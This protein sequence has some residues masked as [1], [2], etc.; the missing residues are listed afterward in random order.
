[1][2]SSCS[3]RGLILGKM[4]SP[5][6]LPNIGIGCSGWWSDSPWRYLKDV[7]TWHLGTWFRGGFG[8]AAL[9]VGWT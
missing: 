2:A 6:G 8:S 5:K 1:M 3:S 4:F 9:M 7:Q